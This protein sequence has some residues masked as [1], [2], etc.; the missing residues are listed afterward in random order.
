VGYKLKQ[1]ICQV[2]CDYVL[3]ELCGI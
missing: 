3:Y 2:V 1:V